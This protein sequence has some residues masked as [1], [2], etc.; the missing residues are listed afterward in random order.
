M[1]IQKEPKRNPKQPNP[2]PPKENRRQRTNQ[3]TDPKKHSSENEISVPI[4]A[5]PSAVLGWCS[6]GILF[7]AYG[8]RDWE[9]DEHGHEHAESEDEAG[10]VEE[11][12]AGLEAQFVLDGWVAEG[13]DVR[14][15][16]SVALGI[17]W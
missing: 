9:H 5:F 14:V 8:F 11:F 10:D 12:V 3:N 13:F 6:I 17:S 2:S 7:P 15:G 16:C 1:R 4:R